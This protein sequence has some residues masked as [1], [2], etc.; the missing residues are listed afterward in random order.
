MAVMMGQALESISTATGS[1]SHLYTKFEIGPNPGQHRLKVNEYE[2]LFEAMI[3][4][5]GVVHGA[6]VA[7]A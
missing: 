3:R 7:P 4:E 2:P 5:C 1:V 6:R